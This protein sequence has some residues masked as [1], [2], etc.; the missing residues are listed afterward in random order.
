MGERGT[1]KGGR[2]C[3]PLFDHHHPLPKLPSFVHQVST[4]IAGMSIAF[5]RGPAMAAVV[6]ATL[7]IVALSGAGVATA[8][9]PSAA[10]V[11]AAA[12][13]AATIAGE[14]LAGVKTVAAGGA[15]A[16]V[17][18]RYDDANAAPQKVGARNS[19]LQGVTLG[20]ANASFMV[21]GEERGCGGLGWERFR[22]KQCFCCLFFLNLPIFYRHP[23]P[24]PQHP[25]APPPNCVHTPPQCPGAGERH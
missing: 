16:A 18:T 14:A 12:A 3:P 25:P 21:S 17:V 5:A 13:T 22:W 11:N 2:A 23:C 9:A 10:A 1:G 7:P 20:V 15:A 19:V 8:I 24:V 6:L 4:F